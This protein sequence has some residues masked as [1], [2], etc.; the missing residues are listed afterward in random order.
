MSRLV[1]F[2]WVLLPWL[3]CAA[4]LVSGPTIASAQEP[5][6]PPTGT[7]PGP[8]SNT[9]TIVLVSQTVDASLAT[10]EEGTVWADVTART[11]LH[12]TN[13]MQAVDATLGWPAWAGGDTLFDPAGLRDFRVMRG[14]Q[15]L[16]LMPDEYST[17]WGGESRTVSWWTTTQSL[18]R[19]E[20]ITLEASWQQ[21][22]GDGPL[23]TFRFGLLPA[24][25][26]PAAIGSARVT[27][28]LP[29]FTREEQIVTAT[30]AGVAFD[31]RRVEWVLVDFEPAENVELTI[32]APAVWQEIETLRQQVDEAPGDVACCMAAW[33]RLAELYSALS[34]A[35][36]A[37]YEAEARSALLAARRAAPRE[38]EPHR[39]LWQY[40]RAR[41][42]DPPDLATLQVAAAEA[43]AFLAAGGSDEEARRFIV[44]AY[45]QLAEAWMAREVPEQALPSFERALLYATDDEAESLTTQYR[46][47]AE[48]LAL[49]TMVREGVGAALVV[50]DEYDLTR[51]IARPWLSGID[52]HVKTGPDRRVI[53]ATLTGGLSAGELNARLNNLGL[54][55][56]ENAPAGT[57]VQWT[58]EGA[59][60]QLHI[61]MNRADPGYWVESSVAL[62]AAVPDDPALD[63]L[64]SVLQPARIEWQRRQGRLEE[65]LVYREDVRLSG[66]AG[67]RAAAIA[68]RQKNAESSWEAALAGAAADAW[69]RLSD[70]Q[71]VRYTAHFSVGG[72]SLRRGWS[73]PVPATRQ[74]AFE[75]EVP[76]LDRWLLLGGA[77]MALLLLALVVIWWWPVRRSS[78]S[79]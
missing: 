18:G 51:D 11:R 56:Q 45:R 54:A 53:T 47:A 33:L 61:S 23:V 68:T 7:A 10:A 57:D 16:T 76:H 34:E 49:L 26:W 48:R 39:R 62:L 78:R 25:R 4:I 29:A 32:I 22:L 66:R 20:R 1:S 50:A 40:Y 38:P 17:A 30:P 65:T 19:D 36:A 59:T 74:L 79:H 67:E 28:E 72:R 70:T 14:D 27:V 21:P 58:A 75:E 69:R 55:L 64:R 41:L 44:D 46:A 60:G 5:S 3:V 37:T 35:G 2:R 52:I 71:R 77:G 42:G 9:G 63:V 73:L 12:Q 15:R 6:P 43:E 24:G 8:L 13:K 31:G